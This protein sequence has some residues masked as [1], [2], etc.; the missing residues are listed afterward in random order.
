MLTT[1]YIRSPNIKMATA[2]MKAPPATTVIV[3]GTG[4]LSYLA[5]VHNGFYKTLALKP[6]KYVYIM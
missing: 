6:G 2:S 1:S 3:V 4:L 5:Y